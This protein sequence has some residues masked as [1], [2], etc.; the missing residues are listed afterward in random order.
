LGKRRRRFEEDDEDEDDDDEVEN[1]RAAG[2][3]HGFGC[4]PLVVGQ[5]R[6]E[7]RTE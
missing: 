1:A 3:D 5:Q 4:S 7:R 6:V 2:L